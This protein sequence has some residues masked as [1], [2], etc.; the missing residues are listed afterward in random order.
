MKQLKHNMKNTNP[1]N[2]CPSTPINLLPPKK[3][4]CRVLGHKVQLGLLSC[5]AI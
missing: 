5:S 2:I 3:N 4:I 1:E